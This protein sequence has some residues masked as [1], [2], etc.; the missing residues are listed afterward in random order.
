MSFAYDFS[1][2]YIPSTFEEVNTV[3]VSH[4]LYQDS[5]R[6]VQTEELFLLSSYVEEESVMHH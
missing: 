3:P 2:Y 4:Y 6:Q 5:K 1:L